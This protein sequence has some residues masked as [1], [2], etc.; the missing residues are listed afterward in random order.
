MCLFLRNVCIPIDVL[1]P[2]PRY[3]FVMPDYPPDVFSGQCPSRE[4]LAT[5]ADKWLLLVVHALKTGPARHGELM[6]QVDGISQPMLTRTLREME[7]RGLVTRTVYAEVPPRVEYVL[8][9]FGKSLSGPVAALAE[10]AMA[11]A[12]TFAMGPSS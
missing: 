3:A 9:E 12:G 7:T 1:Q 4:A 10:W 5:V 6:R 11:N 2:K 8:T